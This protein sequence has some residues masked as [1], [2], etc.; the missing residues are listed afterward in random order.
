MVYN[1][2]DRATMLTDTTYY[3]ENIQ[4]VNKILLANKYP[5]HFINKYINKRWELLKNNDFKVLIIK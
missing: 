2:V 4:I 3:N 1:L 5:K